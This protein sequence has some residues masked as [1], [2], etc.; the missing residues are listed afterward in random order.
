M[1]NAKSFDCFVFLLTRYKVKTPA[2][3]ASSLS[4]NNDGQ[5]STNLIHLYSLLPI[6]L[7]FAKCKICRF[8]LYA[9]VR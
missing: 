1:L 7:K 6:C 8:V 9:A 4:E 2:V 3:Q 5:I